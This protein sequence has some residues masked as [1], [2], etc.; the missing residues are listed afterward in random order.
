MIL[1]WI[2]GM[3]PLALRPASLQVT[4]PKPAYNWYHMRM[5]NNHLD[6]NSFSSVPF[7]SSFNHLVEPK[8]PRNVRWKSWKQMP[9]FKHMPEPFLRDSFHRGWNRNWFAVTFGSFHHDV[10]I[11]FNQTLKSHRMGCNFGLI[12]GSW[13]AVRV[14]GFQLIL[15]YYPIEILSSFEILFS[16][17]SRLFLP[18]FSAN[19]PKDSVGEPP[20]KW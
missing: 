11:L 9:L 20:E 5:C 13:H 6:E 15:N 14:V 4:C 1:A 10:P 3:H 16:I 8:T 2:F 12:F 19:Y 7:R 18:F 17:V